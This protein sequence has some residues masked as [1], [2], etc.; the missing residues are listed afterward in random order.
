MF[1]CNTNH[2][3]SNKSLIVVLKLVQHTEYYFVEF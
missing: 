1:H 2:V 3:S